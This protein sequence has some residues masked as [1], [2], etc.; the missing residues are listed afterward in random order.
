DLGRRL[1][2]ADREA[3]GT[4]AVP[5]GGSGGERT[6]IPVEQENPAT[7]P[8]GRDRARP[9]PQPGAATH[10]PAPLTQLAGAPRRGGELDELETVDPHR[11][12]E[13]GDLHAKVGLGVHGALLS[14]EARRRTRERATINGNHTL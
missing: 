10:P 9:E 7:L 8:S 2:E 6:G 5:G 13:R 14:V 11:V 12:L 4:R 1:L 3:A